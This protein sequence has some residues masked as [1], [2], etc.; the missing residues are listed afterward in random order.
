MGIEYFILLVV[1]GKNIQVKHFA[2]KRRNYEYTCS[3]LE[4]FLFLIVYMTVISADGQRSFL[5]CPIWPQKNFWKRDIS[6][7]HFSIFAFHIA[8]QTSSAFPLWSSL[9]VPSSNILNY[10]NQG[11]NG[12]FCQRFNGEPIHLLYWELLSPYGSSFTIQFPYVSIKQAPFV[13]LPGDQ[14]DLDKYR[15]RVKKS[16]ITKLSL[17]PCQAHDRIYYI[18]YTIYPIHLFSI[19]CLQCAPLTISIIMTIYILRR[20]RVWQSKPIVTKKTLPIPQTT[21]KHYHVPWENHQT[22]LDNDIHT[23]EKLTIMEISSPSTRGGEKKSFV[24]FVLKLVP[25][26]TRNGVTVMYTIS[27]EGYTTGVRII[28]ATCHENRS[29]HHCASFQNNY[30]II[31]R[32]PWWISIS[33]KYCSTSEQFS[34]SQQHPAWKVDQ[35]TSYYDHTKM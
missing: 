11:K 25:F 29:Y 34:V 10:R 14:R 18:Q 31:Y 27:L 3:P 8:L 4:F 19:S 2:V 24:S 23:R 32:F 15:S 5:D 20:G 1:D 13:F 16:T 9:Y 35:L 30:Q 28:L 7:Q 12:F 21:G 6:V 17:W 26:T 33:C 22:V